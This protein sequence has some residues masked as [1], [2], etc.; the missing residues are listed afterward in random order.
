VTA[1]KAPRPYAIC[2]RCLMDTS[3]P[4]IRF[5]RRGECNH[6]QR[7][8]R[9]LPSVRWAPAESERALEQAA[10]AIRLA[11]AGHDYD[12]VIGLSGGVDSSY[13]ALLAHRLGLRPLAVHF[14]NGWDSEIA[15]ENIRRVVEGCSFDLLTYVIDWQEF[16]DLQRSFL[17]ASVID[18]EL[19]TDNAILGATIGLA[20]EH[21]IRHLLSGYN[22]ATEHGLPQA[23]TWHKMD[24]TNI[25][26][27]HDRHGSVPLRTFPHLSTAAWWR[28][29]LTGRG[30]E[31][32]HLPNLVAYRRDDAAA[33]LAREFGWRDYG[34]KHHE[35]AF[36]KYYQSVILPRKF[37]IDKRRVHLSDRIRNGELGR[38]TGLAM[39]TVP[40]YA[41][42]DERAEGDYVRKKLGFSSE[43][44][45]GIMT[46]SPRKH[47]DYP[48]DRWFTAPVLLGL[49]AAHRAVAALS[50]ARDG[51]GDATQA[52]GP[53]GR[54]GEEP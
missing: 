46:A 14:D 17:L 33:A 51:A 22:L 6:C 43:E 36:T 37:G 48:S 15:V 50:R 40:T 45:D 4:D 42:E 29:Q 23:W 34:G 7:A 47:T 20:R 28:M 26:A 52:P 16:R 8:D 12:S 31:W 44:W 19:V 18:I 25:K 3:D 9:Y 11:G 10:A 54:S 39:L 27:I 41:P 49:R 35:S 24:W 53:S 1:S 5:D 30:I 21:G 32:V 2:T 38:G 13:A